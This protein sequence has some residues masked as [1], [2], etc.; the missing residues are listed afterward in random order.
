MRQFHL[1]NAVHIKPC[2]VLRKIWDGAR[3]KALESLQSA[4]CGEPWH[5]Q[6][7]SCLQPCSFA[8]ILASSETKNLST[9]SYLTPCPA[10]NS[11]TS[12][13]VY[14]RATSS[15]SFEVFQMSSPPCAGLLEK[16]NEVRKPQLAQFKFDRGR[17]HALVGEHVCI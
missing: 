15:L 8:G 5:V 13:D 11:R 1:S 6:H 10:C 16:K 7:Q 17:M 9:S 4:N 12:R 3:C 14:L 2:H